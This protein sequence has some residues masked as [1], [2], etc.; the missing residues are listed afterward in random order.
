M[1]NQRMV[2]LPV[3]AGTV[4][5]ENDYRNYE[6]GLSGQQIVAA[7]NLA[8]QLAQTLQSVLI[9][10]CWSFWQSG[11]PFPNDEFSDYLDGIIR[12]MG[13]L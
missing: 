13:R 4:L 11:D 2:F 7:E 3:A 9:Q 8:S 5:G 10:V 6:S 1:G 12:G